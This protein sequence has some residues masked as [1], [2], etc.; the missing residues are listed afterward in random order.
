M[1]PVNTDL[2]KIRLHFALFFGAGG[3]LYPFLALYYKQVG[4][5][6]AQ[7]GLLTSLGWA[8]SMFTA[9][10]WGRWGDT[11]RNP[12]VVLQTA[13]LGAGLANFFLGLQST[14]LGIAFFI[15][16]GSIFDNSIGSLSTLHA[17][18]ATKGEKSG[19][20]SVRLFGSLGWAVAASFAGWLVERTG[21]FVPFA[22]YASCAFAAAIL[23]RFTSMRS[24]HEKEMESSRIPLQQMIGTLMQNRSMLA[25]A[26]AMFIV[27]LT[28]TGRVQFESI[29]M[30]QLGATESAVGLST[31]IGAMIEPPFMLWA[32]KFIRR[33]GS[34]TVLQAALLLQAFGILAI[35]LIPSAASIF[36]FRASQGISFSLLTVSMVSYIVANTPQGQGAT[37][38]TLFDVTMHGLVILVASPLSG[39]LF[40]A[41]G[42][43]WLYVMAFSGS[44]LGCLILFTASRQLEV[45]RESILS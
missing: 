4:L 42:A 6:G 27:W 24:R 2:L 18:G 3:F 15:A 23:I 38:M 39:I 45:R 16:L 32:D 43:Y 44:L 33:Y 12:R 30:T 37:I 5:T 10:F 19:F 11:A 40:D 41:V 31:A 21:L 25:L 26:I 28:G 14:Y 8:I 1:K 22:G 7:M 9:P 35:M 34:S 17:L 29:Y 36:I 13:L 20:G